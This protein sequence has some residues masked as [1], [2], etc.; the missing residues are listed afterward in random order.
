MHKKVVEIYIKLF[1]HVSVLIHHL[2]EVY[3]LC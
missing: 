1:Q 3:N 2:Q